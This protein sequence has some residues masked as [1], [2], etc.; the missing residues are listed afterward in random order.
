MRHNYTP[1]C[2]RCGLDYNECGCEVSE[3]GA[4]D[5]RQMQEDIRWVIRNRGDD[6]EPRCR[7]CHLEYAL[8][9]CGCVDCNLKEEC[10]DHKRFNGKRYCY[11]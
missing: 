9:E 6:G 4:E 2:T 1:K 5:V 11:E 8:C 3:L 7:K 10:A